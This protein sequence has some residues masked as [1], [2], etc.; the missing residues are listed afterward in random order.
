[1]PLENFTLPKELDSDGVSSVPYCYL[2]PN[3][4]F[5]EDLELYRPGH[6]HPVHVK[7]IIRPDSAS[8]A[9]RSRDAPRGYRILHKLG[10]GGEASVWLAQ[11]L[12]NLK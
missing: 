5:Q 4:L 1:M 3:Q 10:A 6:F 8:S 11:E 2:D 7:D 9:L 12:D